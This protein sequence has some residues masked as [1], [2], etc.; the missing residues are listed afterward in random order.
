MT[1]DKHPA[2]TKAI[3]W[4]VDSKV[5]HRH[6]QYLNNH[7]EQNHRGIKQR[8]Y[9]MLGFKQFESASRFCTA[10][11]ELRNYLKVQSAGSD[12]VSADV[13][14]KLFT[15]RRSTLMAELSA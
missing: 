9:P 11:D 5:L 1:T 14:R 7:M 15:S 12:H 2:Y 3:R 6:D 4:I 13:R 10:F 8:Y